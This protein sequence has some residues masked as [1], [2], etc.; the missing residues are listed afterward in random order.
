MELAKFIN[1]RFCQLYDYEEIF[2]EIF[3]KSAESCRVD[4]LKWGACRDKNTNRPYIQGHERAD[5]VIK[6]K[7]FVDYF[8]TDKDLYYYPTNDCENIQ[9]WNINQEYKTT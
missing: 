8:L 3:V 7:E 4:L 5:V 9:D 6:R 1:R 2:V